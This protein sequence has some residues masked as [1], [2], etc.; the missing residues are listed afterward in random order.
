ML[1]TIT[2]IVVVRFQSRAKARF[3]LKIIDKYDKIK[4][5]IKVERIV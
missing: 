5:Y 3:Y 1:S 4:T 2:L